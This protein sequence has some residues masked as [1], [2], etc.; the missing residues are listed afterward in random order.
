MLN[1]RF[2]AGYGAFLEHFFRHT[3]GKLH[4]QQVSA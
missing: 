2:I 1:Q 3:Q 4:P